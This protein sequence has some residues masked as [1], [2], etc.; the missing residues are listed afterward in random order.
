MSK[1]HP[2]HSPAWTGALDLRGRL[3]NDGWLTPDTYSHYFSKIPGGSAVYL[4]MLYKPEQLPTFQHALVAYVGM[5]TVLSRR[6][7]G[8]EVLS[9]LRQ[10][11]SFVMRWFKRTKRSH[12]R[13]TESYY[14]DL[15]DPPWNI[16]G[17]RRGIYLP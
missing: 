15:F 10:T 4:L 8:H 2:I 3:V 14:I 9:E 16:Q 7:R 12:L 11:D 1:T 17:R 13:E 5:A 6:L